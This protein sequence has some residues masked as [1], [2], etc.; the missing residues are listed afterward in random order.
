MQKLGVDSEA[1]TVYL[2]LSLSEDEVRRVLSQ[3]DTPT[4]STENSAE[5]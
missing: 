4:G 2:R 3:I 1:E 5:N